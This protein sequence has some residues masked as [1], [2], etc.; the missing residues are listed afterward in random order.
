MLKLVDALDRRLL[1]QLTNEIPKADGVKSWLERGSYRVERGN[2]IG[3]VELK[4]I[5][6]SEIV[7][8]LSYDFERFSLSSLESMIYSK[9][10]ATQSSAVSWPI[11]KIY[12]SAFFAAHAITRATCLLYTSGHKRDRGEGVD[13]IGCHRFILAVKH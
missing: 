7:P 10:E 4:G 2:L 1:P 9:S 3:S 6:L 8:Y 12:Y 13:M 5:S 11:L